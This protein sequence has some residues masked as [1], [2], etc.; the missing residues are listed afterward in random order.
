MTAFRL[1]SQL[2]LVALALATGFLVF[3]AW[4]WHTI[5]QSKVGGANYD[6]IVLYKDLVADILPPPNYI[7]ESYLT[8]LQLSDPDRR[9]ERDGLIS[10]FGKLH[11]EYETRHQFWLAQQL[12][13]DIKTRFLSDAHAPAQR[14]YKIAEEEFIPAVNS[15]NSLAV[16]SALKNIEAQYSEH[17]K[18]ID[19]VVAMSTREQEIVETV[20]AASLKRGLGVLLLVFVLSAVLA[21]AG[22]FVF[23][24]SLL[25]GIGEA[26]RRLNDIANG[27][28]AA[29]ASLSKRAD[30]VGDLLRTL[31]DTAEKLTVTV[32][33][34]RAAAE[35]VSRR[36]AQLS[37][38]MTGVAASA[39]TQ[40]GS[41]TAVLGTVE[42]MSSGIS[43]M[44]EQ[45]ALARIRVQQAG[46]RCAQGSAEIVST[47]AVVENLAADVQATAES[48]SLLGERSREISGIVTVIRAVADQTNLLALNAAIESARAGEQGR[49]FAVVADE[50]RKLAERTAKSTDQIAT[51]VADIRSGIESAARG[52]SAGSD[53]A[54]ASIS[55]VK[56]ARETMEAIAAETRTLV[57]DIGLIAQNVEAQR[58]GSCG[59]S[60]A[61]ESIA[62]GS[63]ENSAAAGELSS[64]ATDL[65]TTANDLRQAVGFFRI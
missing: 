10:T 14:F 40:S 4:A 3:G 63:E 33:Q 41:V 60:A 50:V 30:E 29:Q 26:R 49:G 59:I 19:D 20:T 32:S 47:A 31:D 8:V 35:T 7:V 23:G 58:Q 64:T 48:V 62:G 61:V 51:M 52:M 6:R 44:A 54:R 5:E 27:D 2:F 34:I 15:D 42:Q 24:R 12:P 39:R 9:S 36:A 43:A 1:R 56:A 18:A 11:K 46:V 45:A 57:S 55:A 25:A 16:H 38:T 37:S 17:R 53:R 22:N 13:E 28:L 65:S 21:A